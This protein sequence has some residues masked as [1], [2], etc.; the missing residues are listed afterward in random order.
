MTTLS[1]LFKN[2]QLFPIIQWEKVHSIIL[3]VIFRQSG[4]FRQAFHGTIQDFEKWC[5]LV[6]ILTLIYHEYA[7]RAELAIY[8]K[9]KKGFQFK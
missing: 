4:V 3:T 2:L 6:V 5:N 8:T 1:L 7:T 9:K